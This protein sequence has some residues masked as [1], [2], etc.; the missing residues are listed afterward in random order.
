MASRKWSQIEW[1]LQRNAANLHLTS[2]GH[3]FY[4]MHG[5]PALLSSCIHLSCVAMNAVTQLQATQLL[6]S[7]HSATLLKPLSY[8]TLI[9]RLSYS[10]QAT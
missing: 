3:S 9:K 1:S 4:N 5:P 2:Q 7:G 6:L 8:G 10:Y